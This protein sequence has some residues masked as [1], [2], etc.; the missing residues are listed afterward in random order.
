MRNELVA[1]AP[2]RAWIIHLMNSSG[3]PWRVIAKVADVE[4]AV[5]RGLLFGVNNEFPDVISQKNAQA[6]YDVTPGKLAKLQ[7]TPVPT[8]SLRPYL[9][10]L[11]AHGYPVAKI[12]RY[13]GL[14]PR[15]ARAIM[16]S[17][18]VWCSKL[19]QLH[20]QAA[21][22]AAGIT[23]LNELA[24]RRMRIARLEPTFEKIAA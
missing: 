11:S 5:A 8:E 16:A 2:F 3:L 12:A 24:M 4:P 10:A 6:L 7:S 20:A 21:C 15:T 17:S 13:A 9:W 1:A 23:C 18:V 14:Q 19:N 22:E